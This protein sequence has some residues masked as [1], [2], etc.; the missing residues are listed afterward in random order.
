MQ[1]TVKEVDTRRRELLDIGEELFTRKGYD[2]TTVSDIVSAAG[3]AQGTFYHHFRSKE[4][5]LEAIADRYIDDLGEML[6]TVLGKE[7]LSA[8]QKLLQLLA[9]IGEY[10]R[11]REGM[12]LHL[13]EERNLLLHHKL[14][15]RVARYWTPLIRA[16][17]VQGVQEGAFDTRYPEEAA[18]ALISI[19]GT[20]SHS[21]DR[22][23]HR[24]MTRRTTAAFFDM[25]ERILGAEA[26]TF[27]EAMDGM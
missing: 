23:D 3:I 9:Q 25:L 24:T 17:I 21:E 11:K 8:V 22:R 18:I 10:G 19:I 12:V 20:F 2:E 1:R 6:E 5:L 15:E 14:E 13:H 4:Q 16:I 27:G 26:G 7:G